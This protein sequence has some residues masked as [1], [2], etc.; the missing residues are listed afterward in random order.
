MG[1]VRYHVNYGTVWV[2]PATGYG[3]HGYGCGVGKPDPR[4]TRV[5]PY[6]GEPCHAGVEEDCELLF[7]H[8]KLRSSTSSGFEG[9]D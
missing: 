1:F 2:L 5:Q 6:K 8:D 3:V 9:A 4:Y 7:Y